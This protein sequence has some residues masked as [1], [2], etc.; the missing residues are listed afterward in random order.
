M[1]RL[2]QFKRLYYPFDDETWP[3]KGSWVK[4]KD[5]DDC[6]GHRGSDLVLGGLVPLALDSKQVQLTNE[7]FFSIMHPAL[8]VLPYI[9]DDMDYGFCSSYYGHDLSS[10]EY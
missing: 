9:Y 6:A 8:D 5:L 2:L 7:E 4:Y 10:I 1:D 3:E